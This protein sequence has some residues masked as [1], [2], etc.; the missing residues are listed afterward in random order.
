M[1][2]ITILHELGMSCPGAI[3]KWAKSSIRNGW[4]GNLSPQE[5]V[6]STHKNTLHLEKSGRPYLR[7][8][9]D[10]HELA[11]GIGTYP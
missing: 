8:W 4:M 7:P 2:L 5:K 1:Q 11:L 3:P 6:D 10:G 9:V